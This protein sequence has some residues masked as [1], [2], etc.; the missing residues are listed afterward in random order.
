MLDYLTRR[1]SIRQDRVVAVLAEPHDPK[2]PQGKIDL[3]A[4]A[5]IG[6]VVIAMG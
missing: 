4:I 3:F 2:L 6:A 5:I 1:E